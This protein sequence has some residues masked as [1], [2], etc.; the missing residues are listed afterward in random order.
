MANRDVVAA[1]LALAQQLKPLAVVLDP[2]NMVLVWQQPHPLVAHRES[3]PSDVE[4]TLFLARAIKARQAIVPAHPH[5]LIGRDERV[6]LAPCTVGPRDR[7]RPGDCTC[8]GIDAGKQRQQAFD[9][10]D[11]RGRGRDPLGREA[12]SG[13]V[14]ADMRLSRLNVLSPGGHSKH[15]KKGGRRCSFWP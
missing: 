12:A 6:G 11:L 1:L 13:P 4:R 8:G 14:V 3:D 5:R 10:P 15:S 7:Q 9:E 2:R